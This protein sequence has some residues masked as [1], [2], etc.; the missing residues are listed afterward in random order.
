[1]A[2]Q[3]RLAQLALNFIPGVGHM[4]VKQL[5]SYCGSAEAVFKTP[6]SKLLKIPGIGTLTAD[7]ISKDVP[8]Q[9]AEVELTKCE[10]EG[11]QILLHTDKSFPK[12]LNHISDAP[13]LL[14][15]KGSA[16]LN[17]SKIVSIVGTRKATSYG[18]EIT[19]NII[20][21]L[22]PH[23]PIIVSG[24]AYGIDIQ[25]HKSALKYELPTIGIL[26]SGVNVIYPAIHR[27]TANKMI[28]HGALISENPLDAKPDAP[29]FPARNRIIA[30]MADAIVV[31][32]A[33]AKGGALITAEIANSYNKDVFA[34]P[35]NVNSEFSVGCNNLIRSN[36]AHLINSGRDIEY[37]M[38]WDVEDK[39]SGNK[40]PDLSEL[41]ENE[42]NI[43]NALAEHKEGMMIDNLSWKTSFSVSQ[44]A[45]ILL[46]LEFKGLVISLPGKRFKLAINK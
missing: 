10:K 22:A 21:Y 12:R 6:K 39:T 20:E 15:V 25:A 3:D 28:E 32:E 31:I 23:N 45:S 24:L 38:N 5:V 44:L 26:A 46:N 13:S 8:I 18:K 17:A 2:N 34:V 16:D 11:V 9:K 29:K 30:G 43:V 33:A 7:S 36:K 37:I 4:L 40:L 27:E 1:M 41:D 19:D 35:G 42:L 14:Y